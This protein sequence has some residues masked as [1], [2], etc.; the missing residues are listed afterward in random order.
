VSAVIALFPLEYVLLP[1]LPLPLHIFEPRYRQMIADVGACSGGGLGA[2]GVVLEPSVGA[3]FAAAGAARDHRGPLALNG[4]FA[5][6]GTMAEILE[7]EPYED[8]RCDLLTVGSRRFRL[9]NVDTTSKP[10]LQATVEFLDEI[11]GDLDI[12]TTATARSLLIRYT[13]VLARLTGSVE[14]AQ[15]PGDALRMSYEIASRLQLTTQDRQQLLASP[16]AAGR[17]RREVDLLRREIALLEAT[18][19]VPVPPQVL[20]VRTSDN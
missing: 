7:N 8:G 16:S 19:A 15:L 5:E 1:G 17:L 18:S 11:D 20:R 14:D 2:F 10:Y 6:I 12:P 4:G 13:S 9:L 3:D